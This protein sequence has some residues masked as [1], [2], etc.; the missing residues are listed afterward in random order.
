MK[1][2][3]FLLIFLCLICLSGF[4]SAEEIAAYVNERPITEEEVQERLQTSNM[5]NNYATADMTQ[6]QKDEIARLAC[7][8]VLQMLIEE[9]AL[10]DEA[11]KRGLSAENE[12]IKADADA[13]YERMIQSA[14]SY[15][16]SSYP[17]LSGEELDAQVDE[18]LRITGASQ[19]NYREIANRSAVLAALDQSLTLKLSSP[20]RNA[21]Q[22]R[23]DQLYAE[24]K[25]LFD[26]DHN[27]FEAAM[28]QK[29]IVVYR[30]KPLK[31]IKKAEFVFEQE[32]LDLIRQTAAINPSLA[33]E[34]RADQ[35]RQL[36]LKVETEYNAVV[37]GEKTFDELLEELNA[38]SSENVNYFHPDSTRFNADY[39]A[40]ADAFK[41]VGEI[42]SIYEMTTGYAILY[43]DGELPSCERVPLEEVSEAISAMLVAEN[44]EAAL[45]EAKANIIAAADVRIVESVSP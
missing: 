6:E 42:S 36:L 38:G 16:L 5:I 43:Y 35:H 37:N 24:Q 22:T 31:L 15:V 30:P 25:A 33:A 13:R 18:L 2:K 39:Y 29:Q 34:M 32:A 27:S 7:E 17:N 21:I 14:E 28:L 3:T 20:D 8:A 23:Y 45:D 12:T 9:E 26:S 11:E 44:S 1:C 40:R 41:N 19:E 10:M 4:C